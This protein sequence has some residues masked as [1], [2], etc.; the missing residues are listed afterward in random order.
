MV[1]GLDVALKRRQP[2]GFNSA[3]DLLRILAYLNRHID[4]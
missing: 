2:I 4:E 3:G 1:A